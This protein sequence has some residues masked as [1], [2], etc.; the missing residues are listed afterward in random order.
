MTKTTADHTAAVVIIGNFDGV[1]RGHQLLIAHAL[2]IARASSLPVEVLSFT[3]HP[4]AVLRGPLSHFLLTPGSLKKQYLEWAGAPR[5]TELAFTLSFSRMMPETFLD[6]ILGQKVRPAHIVVGYNFTFGHKGA[7]TVALLREWGVRRGI[8]IDVVDPFRDPDTGQSIS[9]SGIRTLI[10]SGRIVEAREGLG[11]PFTVQGV[12]QSGD[13]RGRKLD[14]PTLNIRWPDDQALVPYGVYAGRVRLSPHEPSWP[15]VAN[16]GVRPTFGGTTPLLEIH[17]LDG[18]SPDAY[19]KT[20]QFDI[21]YRIRDERRFD[22]SEAL[23]YQ[24]RRDVDEA[25][26]LLAKGKISSK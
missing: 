13:K 16:F 19:G 24:I 2:E 12:V 4:H 21:W 5:L 18:A 25:E 22:S 10:A 23:A 3:P 1:H 6:E 11:H 7:G 15:A 14:A 17:L 8:P 9:S 20:I 26:R